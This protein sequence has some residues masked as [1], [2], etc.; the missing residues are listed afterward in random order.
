MGTVFK[1]VSPKD[2]ICTVCKDV[3]GALDDLLSDPK[4]QA[5]IEKQIEAICP[6]AISELCDELIEDEGGKLLDWLAKELDATKVCT[7]IDAC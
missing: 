4:N 5:A 2:D 1:S 3:L 7:A 6:S